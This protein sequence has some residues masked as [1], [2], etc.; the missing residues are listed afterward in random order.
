[1]NKILIV[2]NGFIG[3]GLYQS[4]KDKYD[5]TVTNRETLDVTEEKT[6]EKFFKDNNS[7]T[8]VIYAVGIKD[9]Q[10]CNQNPDAARDV[11]AKGVKT[12]LKFIQPEKFIYLSTDYVFEGTVG[13]YS[14]DDFTS[15]TTVYGKTK[16][17][18]EKNTL[19]YDKSIVVRT[20]GVFGE[21]CKWILWLL[22]EIE[23]Q[24]NIICYTDVVNTPTY[25][26][27]LAEMIENVVAKKYSGIIHLSGEETMNRMSLFET[28]LKCF[29]KNTNNL[30]K[31][32]SNGLFPKNL[33]LST[34]LYKQITQKE[35]KTVEESFLD[36]KK[37]A[38][39]V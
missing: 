9:I 34:K 14:E 12:I 10:Q 1:M 29:G 18:G 27:N 36:L 25:V 19:L 39:L 2:G 21:K 13:N 20:A 7:F 16:L 24:K 3:Q 32:K 4:Y 28:F 38:I 35:H 5:V 31:G 6:V 23:K 30:I 15:P 37:R 22:S 8:H 33:S 26:N 11:N 17:L